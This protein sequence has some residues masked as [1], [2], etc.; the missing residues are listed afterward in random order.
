MCKEIYKLFT[1][2]CTEYE[3]TQIYRDQSRPNALE[4]AGSNS[5][6]RRVRQLRR[7]CW[8]S[9]RPQ[10][11]LQQC[12]CAVCLAEAGEA[13]PGTGDAAPV[14]FDGE[15]GIGRICRMER[16]E[17]HSNLVCWQY[18]SLKDM[19]ISL[20]LSLDLARLSVFSGIIG[21]EWK[22]TDRVYIVRHFGSWDHDEWKV[23]NTYSG[24]L[25]QP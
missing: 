13:T 23:R 20:L 14:W 1:C 15:W 11:K 25:F 24:I 19:S 10:Y 12:E 3:E 7:R 4:K 9:Y 2:G 8:V 6:D 22:T 18:D 16:R 21:T 17:L 5:S